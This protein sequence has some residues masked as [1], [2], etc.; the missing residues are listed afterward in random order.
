MRLF[1]EIHNSA[2]S[3]RRMTT[4][5]SL[6]ARSV[7]SSTPHRAFDDF[8]VKSGSSTVST[9]AVKGAGGETAFQLVGRVEPP[10]REVQKAARRHYSDVNPGNVSQV[11]TVK[12]FSLGLDSSASDIL[13]S[14][15]GSGSSSTKSSSYSSHSRRLP[16]SLDAGGGGSSLGSGRSTTMRRFVEGSEHLPTSHLTAPVPAP[17]SALSTNQSPSKRSVTSESNKEE[18]KREL[19]RRAK[20]PSARVKEKSRASKSAARLHSPLTVMD[21]SYNWST[22][23]S[24]SGSTM[25]DLLDEPVTYTDNP[26]SEVVQQ[27]YN[28]NI[29]FSFL[30]LNFSFSIY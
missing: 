22:V 4:S 2:S 18:V 13:S 30:F 5:G 24:D 27:S 6:S 21:D 12:E 11:L 17:V 8:E 7:S 23:V 10:K 14:S 20:S 28:R 29:H 19:M 16:L 1:M 9:T 26:M 3:H 15:A 25:S